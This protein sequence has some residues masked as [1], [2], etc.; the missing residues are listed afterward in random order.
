MA[1]IHTIVEGYTGV[2]ASVPFVNGTGETDDPHL[3]EWFRE[4]GYR[5]E[6][7]PDVKVEAEPV[8]RPAPAQKRSRKKGG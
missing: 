5:V 1:K 7:E 2:R 6:E 3:I 8:K 4:H